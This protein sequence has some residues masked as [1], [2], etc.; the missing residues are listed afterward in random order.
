M[1]Y[2]EEEAKRKYCPHINNPCLGKECM[3]FSFVVREYRSQE[4]VRLGGAAAL[5]THVTTRQDKLKNNT[6]YDKIDL[7]H[8]GLT[9]KPEVK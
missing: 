2:S 8:C 1:M 4:P 5:E 9:A 7:Y 3:M 6:C